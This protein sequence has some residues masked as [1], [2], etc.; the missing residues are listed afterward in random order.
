[1]TLPVREPLLEVELAELGG[2]ETVQQHSARKR[3]VVA[4]VIQ[5]SEHGLFLRC[6][7][8]FKILPDY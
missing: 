6:K 8:T 2:C 4:R 3:S 1:M 5:F 7:T